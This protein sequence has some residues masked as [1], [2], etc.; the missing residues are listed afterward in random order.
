MLSPRLR[1]SWPST[2]RGRSL[3]RHPC[4]FTMVEPLAAMAASWGVLMAVSPLL[5]IRR[6]LVRRSSADVSIGYLVVLQIGF[7]LWM[8]YGLSL[9]NLVLVVPNT[10]AFLVGLA[11][12]LITWRFRQPIGVAIDRAD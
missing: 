8:A 9:G 11:T 4:E 2:E 12:M 1:S 10:T 5:Q 3:E 7:S 6:I